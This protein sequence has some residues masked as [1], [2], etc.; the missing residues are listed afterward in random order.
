MRRVVVTGLGM[1]T[2]LAC[3]VEETWAHLLAGQSGAGP[4]TRFDASHL[5][6]TYACEVPRGDGSNGTFNPDHWMEP[7]E[8]RKVDEFILYG[9]AAAIQAVRDSGW[10]PQDEDSRCRTGVMIGSG[11]GGLSAIA[12][13]AVLLKERGPRRVSPFFIP[14]ALINL[15]SGQVSIRYGFKGPNHAVVTACSTGAH[16]IGDAARLI[17]WGDADVM[18]AGGAES[19]ISEIGI[20]GF[21]A[22]KA[23]STK[24]ADNPKAASRP[25]D[26]DRDGFVMGEGAGVVVLEEYEHAKARDAKIYAEVLGYGMSGDAYHIT[27]PAEDGDG[28]LRSMK[29]A[30]ARA[31]LEPAQI[32]YINAH[33]TST[34]ADVIELAAVERLLGEGADKA[35][36]SSTKSAIGH[37]LG[38]AGAVEAIF[39]ILAI[40]DQIAPPTL[41][42]DTPA[43]QTPIDLAPNA[44]RQRKIDIALS[45]SF[46]FGGTNASLILGKVNAG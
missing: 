44:A 21:N 35:T 27:A 36:M 32:D 14:S 20:A 3:G 26:A 5:A 16:A 19:P 23:L 30:V 18:V 4:I 43:V 11:I 15:V 29:A 31:G 34:M 2:P 46:G 22:C 38:A 25:Y 7:K 24:R 28:A 33:G 8:A 41:N 10:M 6:T 42:L 17:Q 39:S 9:M 40:R 37:L 12:D 45:N 13:T 1:V